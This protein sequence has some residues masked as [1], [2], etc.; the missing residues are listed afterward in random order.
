MTIF[1]L[2]ADVL[3]TMCYFLEAKHVG[4]MACVCKDWNTAVDI[5]EIW[6]AQAKMKLS[7]KL[8][9]FPVMSK[10]RWK[11]WAMHPNRVYFE[12][13]DSI[14]FNYQYIYCKYQS[15]GVK[16]L[17]TIRGRLRCTWKT[18]NGYYGYLYFRAQDEGPISQRTIAGGRLTHQSWEGKQEYKSFV[19]DFR[20]EVLTIE[21]PHY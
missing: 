10:E 8:I 17:T 1:V 2:N 15:E 5:Q 12:N 6:E 21:G 13:G 18:D 3:R 7:M 20:Y 14:D 4:A 11:V 19:N 16:L 9:E